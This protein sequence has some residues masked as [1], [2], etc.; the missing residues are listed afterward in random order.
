MN[1]FISSVVDG[2]EEF[3]DAASDGAAVLRHKVTR[4]EHFRASPATPQEACLRE[5]RESDVVVL[6]IGERYGFVQASGMSATHEEYLEAKDRKPIVVFVQR[7]VER[8]P[9]QEEFLRDVQDWANGQY[10]ATFGD[11]EELRDKVTD[12]LHTLEIS[13]ATG[14]VD[15]D[16][17]LERASKMLP[18][19]DRW[20]GGGASLVVAAAGGPRQQVLRPTEIE[21]PKLARKLMAEAMLG[22]LAILNPAAG[23]TPKLEDSVLTVGQDNATVVLTELG[24]VVI[25]RPATSADPNRYGDLP[26]LIEEDL[27]D[28]VKGCLALTAWVMDLVDAPRR[29]THVTPVAHISGGSHLGWKTRAEQQAAPNTYSMNTS[30]E[31]GPVHLVPSA[32]KRAALSHDVT[33][34]SEDFVTLLRRQYR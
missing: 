1:V 4:A 32:R 12:A 34:L 25:T 6:I 7:D 26:V 33:K 15:E 29:L 3:R 16:E 14:P 19:D 21:D 17:L 23:A 10:T 2:M 22:D 13:I 9:R 20:I 11:A 24:D 30:S 27:L 31:K 8:E 18:Q 5:V 28:K